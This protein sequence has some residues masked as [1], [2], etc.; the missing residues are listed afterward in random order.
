MTRLLWLVRQRGTA[1]MAITGLVLLL[2]AILV[3]W[4]WLGPAAPP[5]AVEP[6]QRQAASAAQAAEAAATPRAQLDRFYAQLPGEADLV[7]QLMQ[8][9]EIAQQQG[10]ELTQAD[11]RW[12][13]PEGRRLE[14]YRVEV[15]L[16]ASYVAV[17]GFVGEVLRSM[18][19]ASLDLVQFQRPAVEQG[20]IRAQLAFSFHR[21]AP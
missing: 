19:A 5:P 4:Q 15:S 14:R 6:T 12:D 8:M 11:Y 20:A 18:P 16:T 13:A 1:L 17:R 3:Q 7:R 10:L 21:A 9:Y 2:G